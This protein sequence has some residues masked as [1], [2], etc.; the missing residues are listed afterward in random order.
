[1]KILLSNLIILS[2]DVTTGATGATAVAPKFSDT[3]TLSK[4]R[5]ADSTHHRRGRS[6]HFPVV[7]SLITQP[8]TL[9]AGRKWSLGTWK[10][11]LSGWKF[12]DSHNTHK[13]FIQTVKGLERMSDHNECC[14][15]PSSHSV[16]TCNLCEIHTFAKHK[17]NSNRVMEFVS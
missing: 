1:M 13:A 8:P 10:S 5:G 16:P 9:L 6:L 15:M 17:T 2:R 3:L 4:P 14:S 7:T 12:M 11:C